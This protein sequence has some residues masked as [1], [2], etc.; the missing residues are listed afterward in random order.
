MNVKTIAGAWKYT[1]GMQ[2]WMKYKP[3]NVAMD[4]YKEIIHEYTNN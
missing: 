1:M 3:L 4:S 2:T